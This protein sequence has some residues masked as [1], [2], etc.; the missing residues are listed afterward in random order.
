MDPRWLPGAARAAGVVRP[1]AAC[2][3]PDD[4]GVDR[5]LDGGGWGCRL[6]SLGWRRACRP[7]P[8]VRGHDLT[9]RVRPVR[10]GPVPCDGVAARGCCLPLSDCPLFRRGVR[11]VVTDRASVVR[12]RRP[13]LPAVGCCCCCHRCCQPRQRGV[14]RPTDLKIAHIWRRALGVD[15]AGLRGRR[16]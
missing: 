15:A 2:G 14:G 4:G 5:D 7:G 13:P 8:V 3:E 10:G 11:Q 1:E 9:L 16:G 6:A 12:C